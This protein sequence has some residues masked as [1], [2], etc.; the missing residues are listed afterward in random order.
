MYCTEE[1]LLRLNKCS[2][3]YKS[4][5]STRAHGAPKNNASQMRGGSN[6]TDTTCPL[7]SLIANLHHRYSELAGVYAEA[8]PCVMTI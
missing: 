2:F 6:A 4:S 7:A 1:K 5:L 3:S 8:I